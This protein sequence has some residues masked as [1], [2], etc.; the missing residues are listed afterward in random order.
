VRRTTRPRRGL[1]GNDTTATALAWA[2]Y[3][4]FGDPKVLGELRREIDGV[5]GDIMDQARIVALPYLEATV[6]EVLRI[7]CPRRV[8]GGA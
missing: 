3:Y 4:I 8:D 7:A 5:G 6:K 1:A 2:I